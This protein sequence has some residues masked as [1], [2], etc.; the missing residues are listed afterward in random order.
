MDLVPGDD[1]RHLHACRAVRAGKALGWGTGVVAVHVEAGVA[2]GGGLVAGEDLDDV[3]LAGAVAPA[4][5][6]AAEGEAVLADVDGC[7][8]ERPPG[9]AC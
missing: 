7:T 3:E 6:V 8:C 1:E 9:D 4:G 2:D 5:A